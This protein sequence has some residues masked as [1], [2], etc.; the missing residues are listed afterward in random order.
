MNPTPPPVVKGLTIKFPTTL[1]GAACQLHLAESVATILATAPLVTVLV[2]VPLHPP[3]ATAVVGMAVVPPAID[4]GIF[5]ETGDSVWVRLPAFPAAAFTLSV[6]VVPAELRLICAA[7]MGP[8]RELS[9]VA[10]APPVA[11]VQSSSHCKLFALLIDEG[12]NSSEPGVAPSPVC[13]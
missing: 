13:H 11:P 6:K 3:A 8:P 9:T 12:I 2:P 5:P 4:T 1:P 10:I 7:L